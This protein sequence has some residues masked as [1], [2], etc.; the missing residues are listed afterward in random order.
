MVALR[1]HL[2]I[3]TAML[4][5]LAL[6]GAIVVRAHQR[7]QR[8]RPASVVGV[9]AYF[10]G[11]TPARDEELEQFLVEDLTQLLI[12]TDADRMGSREGAPRAR[13]VSELRNAKVI[14]ARGPGLANAWREL[15]DALDRW[16]DLPVRG[17]RVQR[18]I[19][20]LGKR[21]QAVSNEFARLG[22]GYYLQADAMLGKTA[23]AIVF[24]YRVE[25]VTFVH[26]GGQRRRVLDLRRLDQL[27]LDLAML[28]RQNDESPDPVVL[29]DRIDHFIDGK[30]AGV[31]ASD[32]SAGLEIADELRAAGATD[33]EAI[34]EIVTATVRRHEA[35]HGLD[36]DRLDAGR[37]LRYPKA[38]AA[39]AGPRSMATLRAE[40]ELAA[41]LSQIGN[42]PIAPKLA[43]WNLTTVGS[44]PQRRK[45]AEAYAARVVLDGL[46]RKLDVRVGSLTAQSDENLR[47][48]A[49]S[50]WVDLYGEPMLPITD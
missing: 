42:E 46:S 39:L 8:G 25:Q 31:L 41:Y 24:V 35:R 4:M 2:L 37:P 17:P 11:G 49:R 34:R 29:L 16:A 15:I 6:A 32:T 9:G 7:P 21:A 23:H 43:L 40:L 28:G 10:H 18:A 22:V 44:N 13:R 3:T 5:T 38:L 48:A 33:R 47:A 27:N 19:D 14:A 30:L 26:V 50:L 45:S 12:E 1:K 36:L 20:E